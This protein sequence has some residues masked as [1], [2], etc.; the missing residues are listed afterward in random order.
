VIR[1]HHLDRLDQRAQL[2]QG[3]VEKQVIHFH[4]SSSIGSECQ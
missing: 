3:A 1:R 4:S 2:G